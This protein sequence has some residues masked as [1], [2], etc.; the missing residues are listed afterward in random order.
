MPVVASI[1]KQPGLSRR[2]LDFETPTS[3]E[4]ERFSTMVAPEVVACRFRYFD[5]SVWRNDWDSIANEGLPVAIEVVL[6]LMPLDE[7]ATLR[8]SPL[9]ARSGVSGAVRVG[10]DSLSTDTFEG[11]F[12]MNFPVVGQ[13]DEASDLPEPQLD[14]IVTTLGLSPLVSQRIVAYLPASP[15]RQYK[16]YERIKPPVRQPKEPVS[17]PPVSSTSLPSAKPTNTPAPPPAPSR[18]WI[19][20]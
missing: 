19:R 3:P 6:R 4:L 20:Q 17:P 14:A 15:A 7:V 10:A 2:E 5:G 8:Q 9:L 16:P 1:P 13:G 11:D 18:Q 12:T